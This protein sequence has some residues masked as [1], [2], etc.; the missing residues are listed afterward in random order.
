MEAD[1]STPEVDL[2][3]EA[4]RALYREAYDRAKAA[5][6]ALRDEPVRLVPQ[7]KL[8]SIVRQSQRLALE[9]QGGDEDTS[10]GD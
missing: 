10:A 4:A 5:G 6:L 2:D 1:G 3:R 9:G 7:D 8:V